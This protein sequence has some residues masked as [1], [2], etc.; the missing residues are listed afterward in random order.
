MDS[1]VQTSNSLLEIFASIF[2]IE[3]HLIFSHYLYNA[4][5]NELGVFHFFL[6]IG[7]I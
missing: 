7:I 4:L 5:Y 6:W 2:V 3:I 1:W